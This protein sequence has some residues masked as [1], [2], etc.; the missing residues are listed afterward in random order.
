MGVGLQGS[1]KRAAVG[2]AIDSL[3]QRLRPSEGWTVGSETGPSHSS[4]DRHDFDT[5]QVGEAF[6][7]AAASRLW[8]ARAR[9]RPA[10]RLSLIHISEP[11]RQAEIS[12]AVF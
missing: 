6:C 1:Q 3:G 5:D 10:P 2:S 11:T 4:Q 7:G 8:M 12:Y 9:R